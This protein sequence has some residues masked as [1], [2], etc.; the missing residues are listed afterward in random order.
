MHG[1]G[2]WIEWRRRAEA[3]G[4]NAGE[5]HVVE[6]KE[7]ESEDEVIEECVVGGEDDDDFPRRDDEKQDEA[8]PAREEEH[9]DEEKFHRQREDHGGGVEPVGEMLNVPTDPG[10]ERAVLVVLVHCGEVA[11]LRIAAQLL[12]QA[13]LEVDA[14]PLPAE[15]P[16]AYARWRIVDAPAGE[17]AAGSEEE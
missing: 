7:A 11:P 3:G 2:G 14:E 13:R 1:D 4:K 5:V 10:G 15:Q 12:H 17:D 16:Q 9:E 8:H 6:K